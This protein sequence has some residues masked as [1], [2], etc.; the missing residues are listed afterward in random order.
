MRNWSK[1]KEEEQNWLK[2]ERIL[3]MMKRDKDRN[4]TNIF[5]IHFKLKLIWKRYKKYNIFEY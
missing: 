1:K 5:T 3:T 4:E 2:M